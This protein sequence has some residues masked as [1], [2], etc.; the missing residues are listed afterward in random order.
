M[1]LFG[2]KERERKVWKNFSLSEWN[3]I[4]CGFFK[5]VFLAF[6]QKSSVKSIYLSIIETGKWKLFLTICV[7]VL[8]KAFRPSEAIFN[9][10]VNKAWKIAFNRFSESLFEFYWEY[11][12]GF[13][14]YTFNFLI[15]PFFTFE[16]VKLAIGNIW[17]RTTCSHVLQSLSISTFGVAT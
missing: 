8:L 12:F 14:S 3:L 4:T 6:T 1:S 9:F 11:G 16:P 17:L 10:L 13:F 5:V 7:E 2:E 15:A